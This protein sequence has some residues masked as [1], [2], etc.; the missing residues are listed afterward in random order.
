MKLDIIFTLQLLRDLHKRGVEDR[1][2]QGFPREY[3][4]GSKTEVF[5]QHVGMVPLR[6]RGRIPSTDRTNARR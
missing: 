2:N 4:W 6:L 3:Y 5:S 1:S